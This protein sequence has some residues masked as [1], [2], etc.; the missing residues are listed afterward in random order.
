MGK[1]SFEDSAHA[2]PHHRGRAKAGNTGNLL[3]RV[4]RAAPAPLPAAGGAATASERM[5]GGSPDCF[6]F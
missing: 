5:L 2:G 3:A 6:S 1:G 4:F